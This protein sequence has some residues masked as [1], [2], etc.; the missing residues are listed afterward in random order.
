MN[1]RIIV[2]LLTPALPRSC[3]K[4]ENPNSF[5]GFCRQGLLELEDS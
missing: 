4:L 5:F 3:F 1:R 2:S